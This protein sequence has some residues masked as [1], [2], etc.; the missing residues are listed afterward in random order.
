MER[1]HIHD[2]P[3]EGAAADWTIA[4]DWAHYTPEEHATWD[5]LFA[6]QARQLQGRACAAY[7]RN[8]DALHLS[9]P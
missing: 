2:A 3:P 9:R 8:L 5:R 1:L 6:R 7:L 4:Q